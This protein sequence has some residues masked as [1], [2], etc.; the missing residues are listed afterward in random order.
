MKIKCF[1]HFSRLLQNHDR[2]LGR[3][4]ILFI[5]N[6]TRGILPTKAL[7]NAILKE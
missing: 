2:I 4:E 3:N 6:E 1:V 5:Q 7:K